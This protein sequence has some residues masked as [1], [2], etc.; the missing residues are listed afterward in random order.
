MLAQ[1]ES[2]ILT[3]FHATVNCEVAKCFKL[4][5]FHYSLYY[6]NNLKC[7]RL[8]NLPDH[9]SKFADP[10]CYFTVHIFRYYA[11]IFLL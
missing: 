2:G 6:C 10:L 1:D 5:M 11:I 7:N 3:K 8:I 9:V 4:D